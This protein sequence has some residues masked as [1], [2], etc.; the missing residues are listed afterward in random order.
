M[1]TSSLRRHPLHRGE[2]HDKEL[3]SVYGAP[4]FDDCI[5]SPAKLITVATLILRGYVGGSA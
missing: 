4:D 3:G 5:A 2:R 1:K